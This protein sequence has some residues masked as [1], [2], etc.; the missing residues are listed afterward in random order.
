MNY[1]F[2]TEF[3][4]GKQPKKLLGVKYGWTKPIV[5]LISIGV[6][7][8]D[9]REYYA[10]SNE[11]NLDHAWSDDWIRENVLVKIY[12]DWVPGQL[13]I[14]INFTKRNMRRL[15]LDKGKPNKRIAS[16]ILLFSTQMGRNLGDW[17]GS[18]DTFVDHVA[19]STFK[20]EFTPKFWAYFAST[21]WVAFYQLW[22]KMIDGP[23]PYPF[24]VRDLKNLMVFNGLSADWKR[25]SCPDPEDEHN[26]LG[27]ARWNL[28]LYNKIKTNLNER[29]IVL[30][31]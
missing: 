29:G 2:D 23:K 6:V 28:K 7:A 22:G 30:H 17:D 3:I 11:F 24:F 1:F 25:E 21:D 12:T 4:E 20:D 15:L 26:A 8:E 19:E 5:D 16:E 18:I 14:N 13:R 9:G 27:D 10:V 31:T